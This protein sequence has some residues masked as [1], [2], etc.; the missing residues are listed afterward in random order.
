M[1]KH[2]NVAERAMVCLKCGY[3]AYLKLSPAVIVLVTK[4]DKILLQRN[5]HYKLRNWTLVAG[6]V[7]AGENFEDAV[8]RELWKRPQLRLKTFAISVLKLGRSHQI[9]WLAFALSTHL[10]SLRL[11]VRRLLKL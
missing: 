9:L 3:T 10:E 2:S 5:T 4:G 1:D 6:F 11:T 7:D 8:R